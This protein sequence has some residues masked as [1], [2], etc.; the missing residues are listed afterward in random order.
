MTFPSKIV[1]L[2]KYK[3]DASHTGEVTIINGSTLILKD[4]QPTEKLVTTV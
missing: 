1:V 3:N 4:S 2:V